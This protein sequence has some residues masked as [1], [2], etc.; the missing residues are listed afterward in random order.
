MKPNY[1]MGNKT[2]AVGDMEISPAL[3]KADYEELN[4]YMTKTTLVVRANRF[5]ACQ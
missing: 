5:V 2:Y 1:P 3:T 4:Q